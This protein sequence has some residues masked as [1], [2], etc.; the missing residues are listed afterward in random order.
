M[1][2]GDADTNGAIVGTIL[3]IACGVRKMPRRFVDKIEEAELIRE[4]G[5]LLAGWLGR[6]G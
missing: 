5:Q 6:E 3:G 4:S 2:G 1:G